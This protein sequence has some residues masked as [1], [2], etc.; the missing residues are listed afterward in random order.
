M[1]YLSWQGIFTLTQIPLP[2]SKK[3]SL[4]PWFLG[5]LSSPDAADAAELLLSGYGSP[6]NLSR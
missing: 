5:S 3:S 4:P 1:N 2:N 6:S